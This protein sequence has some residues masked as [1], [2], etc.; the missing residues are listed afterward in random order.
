[1]GGSAGEAAR[2][3]PPSGAADADRTTGPATG[4]NGDW[5][6]A[7]PGEP[8]RE[9]CG[10]SGREGSAGEP[11]APRG[12]RWGGSAGA[13]AAAGAGATAVVVEVVGNAR[14]AGVGGAGIR[15]ESIW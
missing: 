15:R 3:I 5:V 11:L 2:E 8:G 10:E 1:M 6:R 12:W 9:S 7:G 13:G 14:G 4:R